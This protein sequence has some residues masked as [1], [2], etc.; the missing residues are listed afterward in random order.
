M[1]MSI[2]LTTLLRLQPP[3]ARLRRKLWGSRIEDMAERIVEIHPATPR[4]LEPAI[5]LPG[6]FDRV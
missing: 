6:M 2:D 1:P 3:L 5:C 4:T